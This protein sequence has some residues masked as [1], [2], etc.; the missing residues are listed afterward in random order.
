[1]AKRMV[2]PIKDMSDC[3]KELK[4]GN[5]NRSI[6]S[7]ATSE[8][9]RILIKSFGSVIVS[10]R[11]ASDDYA[12]GDLDKA[13]KT[14]DEA[15]KLFENNNNTR[16]RGIAHNN[17]GAVEL[18][19]NRLGLSRDHYE[20][21]IALA[22]E[23]IKEA[24]TCGDEENLI[25]AKQVLSDRLGN[26]AVLLIEEKRYADAYEKL[27]AA[28]KLDRETGHIKGWV[29]KQGVR[30][31]LKDARDVV[32]NALNYLSSP[33]E[34]AFVAA[35]WNQDEIG[36]SMQILLF[37]MGL[38]EQRAAEIA[39][40]RRDMMSQKK[41]E[42]EAEQL[43]IR[44]LTEH[45]NMHLAT[46][47]KTLFNIMK[48][49]QHRNDH[50]TVKLIQDLM[51]QNNISIKSGSGHAG[52]KRVIFVLDYSGSMSGGKIHS[53]SR[54]MALICEE[55]IT[56]E[57]EVMVITFSNSVVTQLPMTKK[58]GNHD[59]IMK[60]IRELV[61]PQGGT[62]LRDAIGEAIEILQ[63]EETSRTTEHLIVLTDG[64]DNQSRKYSQQWICDKI[65]SCRHLDSFVLVA[66]GS[67][68]D[69]APLVQ[70][71]TSSEKGTFL[72]AN[73]DSNGIAKAFAEVAKL[74]EGQLVLEEF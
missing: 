37:Q 55:H 65:S 68:L 49:Y 7:E 52:P 21:A 40:G 50:A 29:V 8:D 64:D 31:E 63:R 48:L 14:F 66:V 34:A 51:L 16:G 46:T 10:L 56:E 54:N 39:N 38:I 69:V 22:R 18:A 44:S 72:R 57:D 17:L 33:N 12:R 62:A 36:P 25:S 32:N 11:F 43:F 28:E 3:C 24:E 45:R 13:K 30:C 61:K 5:L 1:M 53:A 6:Q 74:I 70:M 23:L 47:R 27:D 35:G 59:R 4:V 58:K 73:G 60:K 67:N 15:L 26:L 41:Y 9:M 2:T 20:R 71:V 42:D 19:S